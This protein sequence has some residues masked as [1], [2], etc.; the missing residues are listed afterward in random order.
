MPISSRLG[1]PRHATGVPDVE[2]ASALRD[3]PRKRMRQRAAVHVLELPADGHAVRDTARCD[4]AR[5]RAFAQEVRGGFAFYRGIRGEDHFS[6]F[7][8]IE[9]CLEL[10]RADLFRTDA[11]QRRQ[12]SMQYEVAAPVTAGLLHGHH[13]GR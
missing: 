11:I 4:P 3:T 13:I 8:R 5:R 2:Y 7:A 10:A 12:M 6:H 9:E 1:G